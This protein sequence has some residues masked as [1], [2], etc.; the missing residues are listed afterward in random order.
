[1][2]KILINKKIQIKVTVILFELLFTKFTQLHS[3]LLEARIA[4]ISCPMF[5]TG[6]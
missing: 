5:P 4:D 1:M 6:A 3:I 2:C